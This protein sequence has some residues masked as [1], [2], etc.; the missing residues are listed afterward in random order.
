MRR[1]FSLP[2]VTLGL[3]TIVGIATAPASS[4]LSAPTSGDPALISAAQ[5][6]YGSQYKNMS[7]ALVDTKTN[8]VKYANFGAN[9]TSEYEIGSISKTFVGLLMADAI[10][11]G[12]VTE[13]TPLSQFLPLSA[14]SA[15][16]KLT[17]AELASHRSGLP[18]LPSTYDMNIQKAGYQYLGQ[19]LVPFTLS[20]MLTQTRSTSPV[21]RGVYKYSNLGA[22]LEGH[23]LAGAAGTNFKT[24][25]Q[26]RMLTPLGL[27]TTRV[28]TSTS[29]VTA[30]TTRGTSP[31]GMTMAPFAGEGYAPAATMR[32]TVSDMAKYA[33]SVLNDQ[34]PGMSAT[35]PRW[36]AAPGQKVGYNWFIDSKGRVWHNGLTG[37]F[38]SMLKV[39]KATGKAIVVLSNRAVVV[40]SGADALL[41]NPAL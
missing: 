2:L 37:G 41:E 40:D 13:N 10:A 21:D 32:S 25:L 36:D 7:I 19:N 28:L 26:N 1:K 9:N 24:L 30:Q 29:D 5:T 27:S 38:A 35:T 4:A 12:E 23:A 15:Q 18:S 33:T 16:G 11:R 20:Q 17:L 39:D 8:T 3:A 6:Q 14:T 34:A 22:S 31:S